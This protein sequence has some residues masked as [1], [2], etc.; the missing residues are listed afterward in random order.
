MSNLSALKGC[1]AVGDLAALLG[2]SAKALGYISRGLPDH[3]KY[4]S[5]EIPKRS[6]GTRTI[7]A[8]IPQL[9]LAQGRLAALLQDCQTEIEATLGV[10]NRLAH[11]FRKDHSILTNASI[12]RGQRY[13]LNFDLSDFFGS[14]SFSRVLG[15]FLKNRHF[16]LDR[17]VALLIAQLSCHDRRLPQ[18]SPT[19]PVISNLIGGILDIRIAKIARAQGCAYSRYAD[20]ISI[21]T[22]APQFPVSIATKCPSTHGWLLSKTVTDAVLACGFKVNPEKT[23]LTH[24]ISRQD[25]TGVVVNK[26]VNVDARYRRRLRAMV[27]RLRSTGTYFLER[28]ELDGAASTKT[29]KKFGTLNQLRG[30]L[31]FPIQVERFRLGSAPL[32]AA[33]TGNEL[34]L[35][36]FLFYTTFA[37]GRH[38][39]ILAEGKTD[40]IY[41]AAA[42]RS[43]ASA[44]PALSPPG[45]GELLV[46]FLRSTPSIE[47]LF[48][49]KGGQDPLQKFATQYQSEYGPIKGPKGY[50]PVI[51][52]LDNDHG[53]RQA[54]NH[55]RKH[56][57]IA[58]PEG[59][60]YLHIVD[61]LYVVLSSEIGESPHCIEDCFDE[62]TRTETLSG[63]TLH[64]PSKGFDKSKHYGKSMFA[65]YVIKP[66]QKTI[67]FS[68]FE[69]LLAALS[70]VID[71]HAASTKA[72]QILI[73]K[74]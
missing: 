8:P 19:S 42:I 43:L 73:T 25:V 59:V 29:T 27:H 10:K 35:R 48:G 26:H 33:L 64:V 5:F 38:P 36:R 51:I 9:K 71:A 72:K 68:G 32:P 66:K 13:V 16:E 49:L 31:S 74:S 44:F 30:M 21:S 60:Q 14:I 4:T 47:R 69:P 52:L 61:N 2:F 1:T 58:E 3:L 37:N 11:G 20:D 15:F 53:G 70:Q 40:S 62:S 41:L 46:R 54:L 6:G 39:V 56:Y 18:G 45:G 50:H 12:H 34:L 7:H 22:S 65:E 55:I 63:K 24:R 67:D 23:R 28:S 57:K 17:N